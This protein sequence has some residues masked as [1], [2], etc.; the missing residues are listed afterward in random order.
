MFDLNDKSV[1]ISCLSIDERR[2]GIVECFA[3]Q[4]ISDQLLT[5]VHALTGVSRIIFTRGG[6]KVTQLSDINGGH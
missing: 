5:V 4:L 6:A 1:C 3:R 2:V